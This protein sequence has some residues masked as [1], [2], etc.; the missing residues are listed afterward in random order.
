M[1]VVDAPLVAF[2]FI[3]GDLTPE[4]RELFRRDQEWMT[5]P[6]LNH[7]FLNILGAVGAEEDG[8]EA[9]EAIWREAR[10]FLAPRQQVPDPL[11][12]LRLAMESGL[13]GYEAQYLTLART[14]GLPL[15][16]AS[17]RLL[18]VGQQHGAGVFSPGDYLRVT[19]VSRL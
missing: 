16:S 2:L 3:E 7:E 10:A 14:L 19:E 13:S 18:A 9:I 5:P 17:P 12:S 4:A 15:V 8:T 1:I 11:A 6:I